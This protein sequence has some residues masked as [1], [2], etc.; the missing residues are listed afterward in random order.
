MTAFESF[1]KPRSRGMQLS[2]SPA[3][4]AAPLALLAAGLLLASMTAGPAG[5]LPALPSAAQPAT[6]PAVPPALF[7]PNAG[8]AASGVLFEARG[9]GGR[10]RF[11]AGEVAAG[12]VRMRFAG[13][14][15]DVQVAG[16]D[17]R[18]GVVNVLRG[19]RAAWRTGL[20]VYGGVA[21][22]GLYAGTD[23]RFDARG[24]TWT[25]APGADPARIGWHVPGATARVRPADRALEVLPGHGAP[26]RVQPAPVAWQRIGDARVGV[27]VHWRVDGDG[28]IG[29][30]VGR[31]D[32]GAPLAIA[33][34]VA[35]PPTQAAL[36]RLAFSTFLGGLHWDEAMDVETDASGSTYVAGFTF[37]ENARTARPVRARNHGG[38]DAYVAKFSPDGRRLVYATYLGGADLDSA[39]ALAI[40]RAGNAY[41]AGRTGSPDFPVR[42][43][44]QGRLTGR[45]CQRL[46]RHKQSET[47][48][49][50]FV[51]KLAASGG[52]LVYSTYLGGSRNEEA[53]G[54]AVDR[55]GRAHLTGNTDSADF[56][57]RGALQPRFGTHDCPTDLPC[58]MDAFLT[59]L[60]ADGRSLAYSTYIGGVK[61][62]LAGGVAVGRDGSAYVTGV[63]RS[64]DFPTRRARQ[65]ALTGRACGPPP[66]VPCPDLFVAKVRPS[67]RAFA[68][69]TYLGGKEPETSGGIAIDRAGNAYLTGSTQ[70]TDFPTV[71]AFQTAIGNSSC[72]PNEQ[73][74][75]AF[76]TKL[77]ADGRSL[78]YS[79]F[80]G[81]N[82]EDVGLGI[83]VG[84]D[85]AAHVA[86]ST[87]S[88]GFRTRNPAQAAIGGG[89][90]AYVAT[91]AP[92]G[93]LA[94]ST[95]L[96]GTEAERANGIAVDTR[97]RRHVA[98]RTLSP[99]FPTAAPVQGTNAGDYDVFVT[100][101]R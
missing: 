86:G 58:P 17:R 29:F 71:N 59:K 26:G 68:Y 10:L 90:D 20:P 94:D 77:S 50:A 35:A 70:S 51:A 32:R 82:A 23:A 37:S 9:A 27:D 24:A 7:V 25:L 41:V 46:P 31:H 45:E 15:S 88:R 47:C 18:P 42:R 95:F 72:S 53:L 96:G 21:Y 97:G 49:D 93:A 39:N 34:P 28:R 84:R 74:A 76:V 101:L 2:T 63:T 98:G 54:I 85:G 1:V 19:E 65:R 40:D 61:S 8:Q 5:R 67:G 6:R 33:A 66:S 92:T 16:A 4:T 60:S 36:A 80:L 78:R 3:R 11:S 99:N 30:A 14:R 52:A 73:C 48:H 91:V 62:D 69:S 64:A 79:S 75:D 57:T 87:D 81:G 13:A 22:R 56:P 44:R 38:T 83:A 89:I 43:A 100:M 12:G 55:D